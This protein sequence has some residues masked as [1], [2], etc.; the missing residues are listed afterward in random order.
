ML[1]KMKILLLF[2]SIVILLSTLTYSVAFGADAKDAK[3]CGGVETS[4]IECK[5]TGEGSEIENSGVWGILSITVNILAAGVGIAAIGGFVFAGVLYA[6]ASDSQE[7]VK[8]AKDT[9]RN[10]VIGLVLFAGMYMLI[11]ALVPGGILE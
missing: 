5:Q 2:S 1:A 9:L 7:Q 11:N 6:S 10:V 8:K 4:L 3:T